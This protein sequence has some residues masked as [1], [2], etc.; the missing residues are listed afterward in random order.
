MVCEDM[1]IHR[2]RG[3]SIAAPTWAVAFYVMF[4]ALC[5]SSIFIS[6][7]AEVIRA[8]LAHRAY[9]FLIGH[10]SDFHTMHSLA[11]LSFIFLWLTVLLGTV[12]R[13]SVVGVRWIFT[14][15]RPVSSQ[16]VA[17][18]AVV[19]LACLLA[20]HA[21]AQ[22][23]PDSQESADFRVSTDNVLLDA[24]IH[25]PKTGDVTLQ[26][27]DLELFVD[28]RRTSI[29]SC[30]PLR[31]MSLPQN[32]FLVFDRSR[33]ISS[34][35]ASMPK[36]LGDA[37]DRLPPE[38]R[39]AVVSGAA[40]PHI[41]TELLTPLTVD[42]AKARDALTHL[43]EDY[44]QHPGNLIGGL[45]ESMTNLHEILPFLPK[46]SQDGQ[47]VL[48]VLSD[49]SGAT[50]RS[51]THGWRPPPE[52]IY[53]YNSVSA[54]FEERNIA[55]NLL[56]PFGNIQ[57]QAM[58]NDSRLTYPLF[59]VMGLKLYPLESLSKET[60]GQTVRVSRDKLTESFDDLIAGISS[61]YL[62]AFT[63]PDKDG[64][65]HKVRLVLTK[66]A[67]QRLGESRITTR[68]AFRAPTAIEP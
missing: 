10:V 39:I 31:S 1:G 37:L 35:V 21:T 53:T 9:A 62:V 13:L 16:R 6:F 22:D 24:L 38:D 29:E 41:G 25:S 19:A 49:D 36:V 56:L 63:P 40:Y 5:I 46:D 27:Q 28:G 55:V 14:M 47:T 17:R 20:V 15:L 23:R 44:K 34:I 12:L 66:S 7:I 11:H 42:R 65:L 2:Q 8:I 51:S 58:R 54:A 61:R 45:Y 52:A 43:A 68:H 57:S 18:L 4:L 50:P 30:I 48:I 64:K 60:G 67:R 3:E 32:I 26:K 59:S 33:A